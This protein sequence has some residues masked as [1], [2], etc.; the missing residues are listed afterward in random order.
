MVLRDGIVYETISIFN[1]DAPFTNTY[2]DNS[3]GQI[4]ELSLDGEF[5]ENCILPLGVSDDCSEFFNISENI[6][7]TKDLIVVTD[8]FGRITNGNKSGFY[9][10]IYSDGTIEKK[11]LSNH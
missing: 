2:G 1:T 7:V 8:L 4:S 6:M 5:V 3:F 11:Y 10:N 9:F